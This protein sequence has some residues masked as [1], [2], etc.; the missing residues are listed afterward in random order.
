MYRELTI[1]SHKGPYSA[2]FQAD[3]FEDINRDLPE[4]AHFIIDAKV[5]SLY[6]TQLSNVL[7]S[8]SVLCIEALESNKRLDKF[9]SYVEHLVDRQIRRDHTL[10]AIGGG[11][12]QDIVCFLSATLL[13]GVPWVFYPTTLLA[14]ADSCIGSKSS[15][16][17]GDAKNILG[18]FTPPRRIVID[19]GVLNTLSD[20]DL[21][22]GIGEMLKVHGIDGPGAFAE[23]SADYERLTEDFSVLE[24]YIY[25]SLDIKKELIE[26]DE[27]DQG[28]RNIMNYGHSFGHAIESAS[29]F[30]IP[31]GIAVTMGMDMAHYA[32]FRLERIDESLYLKH[33]QVLKKNYKGFEQKAIS[34]EAF[35]KAI[36]KDKKNVGDSLRLI[37]PEQDG[38]VSI[39]VYPNDEA[40][41][42]ICKAFLTKEL[43][44]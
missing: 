38:R 15:I 8:D 12:T 39:G 21:R 44:H 19:T 42:D 23:I 5:A 40:F 28:A 2:C 31:H 32:A 17:V 26:K 10:V 35:F 37:L 6:S 18:T 34:L 27:F 16:N 43:V 11:I 14:Q 22:S 20:D 30:A 41:Q 13:R 36:S 33:R 24:R 29:N 4:K 3:V 9:T 25:R 1:Q 7:N